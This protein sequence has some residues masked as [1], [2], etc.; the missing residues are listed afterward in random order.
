MTNCC[1]KSTETCICAQEARCSCGAQ[2]ARHCNCS[3]AEVEN[4]KPSSTCSCGMRRQ[5]ECTCSRAAIENS[6]RDGEVDFTHMK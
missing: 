4:S 5:N 6:L 3:R 2:S 1:K